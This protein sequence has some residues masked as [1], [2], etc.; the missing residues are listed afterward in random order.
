MRL[1]G[2]TVT[3]DMIPEGKVAHHGGRNRLAARRRTAVGITP[4]G[5]IDSHAAA[6]ADAYA[7]VPLSA[8]RGFWVR[9]LWRQ[10]GAE[11]A[12]SLE[13]LGKRSCS[14][15]AWGATNA[16]AGALQ[17]DIGSRTPPGLA[18]EG[19]AEGCQQRK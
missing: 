15:A 12:Q 9:R 3:C 8:E 10:V 2:A 4:K 13:A 1:G 17:G 19:L 7:R 11:P 14:G 16:F 5:A 18:S 6:G